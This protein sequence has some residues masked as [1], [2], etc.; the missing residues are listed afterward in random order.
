MKHSIFT[1]VLC[2]GSL[3]TPA[4]AQKQIISTECAT[5]GVDSSAA[6]VGIFVTGTWTGTLQPQGTIQGQT[7]F[8][9][10]VTPST[11]ST[12]QSAITASGGYFALV[13]GY[14]SFQVCGNTVSSGTATVFLN[15]SQAT[16]GGA[17]AA[18]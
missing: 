4:F 1:A 14:S 5:I 17:G 7:P 13:A 2:L 3:A 16:A 11:S 6:V 10:Q 12:A 15:L 8:N 18:P 9:V